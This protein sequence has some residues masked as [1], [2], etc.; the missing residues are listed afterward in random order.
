MRPGP[1]LFDMAQPAR[2]RVRVDVRYGGK[3][4]WRDL[5][6]YNVQL[7]W[8]KLGTKTDSNPSAPARLTLNAPRQLAAKDPTDPLANYGQELCPVLEIRPREGEGWD[9]PFGHFRI[10]ESPANPEEATVSAKDMLLDLEE[11]PLPFPHSP[12]LGGTLLSEMRRLNPVPEHTYIW[13]DPKVRNAA[14]MASLQMPPNRLASVI[15]LADSCGADVRMGYGGKIEAY[16]RRAD[17]ATPDETYPLASKLLIDAQRTEDPSGRLP[18][19]IEINAKGD[20][21]KSYSLSGNKSWADAIKRSE[22]DTEV[23]EALNLLWESKPTTSAWGQK[24]ELYQ[25]AKNTA[26]QWRH[27]LWPGWEREVDDK[28]KTTGWKSNYT[29]DFHIGMQYYGAPYDPKH[30]GRVTKVTD[31]SSDKSWSKMVEQANNDAFHV[32]D[33]L[34]SWKVEMAFDPRIEIGDLLAFEIKEGEWIAI[35]VTSYSCSLSDVS[36][37][38]TVI[39]REARR[40]L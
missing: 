28:G 26:W 17:W 10:T 4:E 11:N 18:N 23:D 2:W 9:V 20:G 35:I 36:R 29:Y 27:N 33:R 5:P 31:L 40:H 34:P 32:R 3:I 8:G 6:V 1:S 37:T 30:Y 38:M 24:D 12:W 21:T 15:M 16:A 22:H 39:G 7:D 25:N 13:V 19:M 14:P